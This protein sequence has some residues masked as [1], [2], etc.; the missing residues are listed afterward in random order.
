[1]FS[2]DHEI[3]YIV[4]AGM[5]AR[6]DQDVAPVQNTA[7][8]RCCEGTK[9]RVSISNIQPVFAIGGESLRS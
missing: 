4:T 5:N 6:P 9:N 7:G 1:M 2:A 8:A 3:F